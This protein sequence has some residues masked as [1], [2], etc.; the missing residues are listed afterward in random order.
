MTTARFKIAIIAYAILLILS[1]PL[2][3]PIPNTSY[4]VRHAVWVLIAGLTVKSILAWTAHQR[5]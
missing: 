4:Q 1:L 3:A 2:T 5:Q